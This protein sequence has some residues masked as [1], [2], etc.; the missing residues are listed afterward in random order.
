MYF[1]WKFLPPCLQLNFLDL[2]LNGLTI[3]LVF[4][5]MF[6]PTLLFG[7][8]LYLKNLEYRLS[9]RLHEKNESHILLLCYLVSR[10]IMYIIF[11]LILILIFFMCAKKENPIFGPKINIFFLFKLRNFDETL[12]SPNQDGRYFV[13][14][15]ATVSA[16]SLVCCRTC[17]CQQHQSYL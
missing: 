2:G 11:V 16:K 4:Q 7:L 9:S 3:L 15:T 14:K 6:P 17:H 13:D 1:L 8:I 12:F 10:N 5:E